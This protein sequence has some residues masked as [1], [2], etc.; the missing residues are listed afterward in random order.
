MFSFLWDSCG[1]SYVYQF[2]ELVNCFLKWLCH[3]TIP[4]AINQGSNFSI[5]SPTLVTI[6]L[7]ILAVLVGVTWYLIV[8]F[9]FNTCL[10]IEVQL[11]QYVVLISGV[12]QSDSVIHIYVSI[13]FQILFCYRLLQDTE[14]SSLCYIV[15]PCCLSILHRV[16]C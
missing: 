14:Y 9:F 8:L 2:E 1:N 11:I 16:V 10:K 5:S 13:L 15:G 6:C 4:L 3:F 7:F 12:Q